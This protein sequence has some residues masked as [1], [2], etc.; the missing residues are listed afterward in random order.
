MSFRSSGKI[1]TGQLRYNPLYRF[2]GGI[3]SSTVKGTVAFR[4][5]NRE[6]RTMVPRT[7]ST[8]MFPAL[9]VKVGLGPCLLR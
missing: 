5:I 1:V 9:S 6:V 8:P 4:L 7:G 3:A 2:Q